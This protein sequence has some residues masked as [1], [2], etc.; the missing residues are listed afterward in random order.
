MPLVRAVRGRGVGDRQGQR[1]ERRVGKIKMA[2]TRKSSRG[3]VR[4]KG[5]ET[6][7]METNSNKSEEGGRKRAKQNRVTVSQSKS[8]SNQSMKRN[9]SDTSTLTQTPSAWRSRPPACRST[10]LAR[11]LAR[12]ITHSLVCLLTCMLACCRPGPRR[13]AARSDERCQGIRPA[14]LLACE[15]ACLL[16]TQGDA[17]RGAVDSPRQQERR[18]GERGGKTKQGERGEEHRCFD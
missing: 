10:G 8:E 7:S 6:A 2:A 14:N 3:R 4:A 16:Q 5:A 1:N 17:R 15:R 13:R 18:A 9:H 12:S 11:S